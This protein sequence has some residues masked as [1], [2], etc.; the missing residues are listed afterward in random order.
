MKLFSEYAHAN[1]G[2]L[3]DE[4]II[5]TLNNFVKDHTIDVIIETGT[6]L[7][8]GSTKMLAEAFKNKDIEL[9]TI[10]VNYPIF[11]QAK[12]NL[13]KYSS[14]TCHYG[15][16]SGI[17]EAIDFIEKDDAILFHENYPDYFID[18][19]SEPVKF[20][21]K[22]IRGILDLNRGKIS[23]LKSF[24]KP[25]LKE[26]LL[27]SLIEKNK[28]KNLLIVLDSAGGTGK[29][30][31]EITKKSL[32]QKSFHVLLDDTHHLK[33]FR[34]IQEIKSDPRWTIIGSSDKH[35]WML[36]SYVP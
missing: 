34:S 23:R 31:F 9:H 15:C 35:G 19:T 29:L 13:K 20:Y 4:A 14:V 8:L 24:F 11:L 22:E 36:A 6:N 18:S 12:E 21:T 10:E 26:N 33:H 28:N 5:D 27:P 32:I 25:T 17:K 2:M 16:S 7:G 1:I 30:E 3:H